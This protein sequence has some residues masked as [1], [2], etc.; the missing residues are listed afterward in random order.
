MSVPAI[1]PGGVRDQGGGIYIVWIVGSWSLVWGLSRRSRNR[2]MHALHGNGPGP[3]GQ[4][5][6]R[7]AT[8]TELASAGFDL[9]LQMADAEFLHLFRR[10]P[11]SA[12]REVLVEAVGASHIVGDD[13]LC[14]DNKRGSPMEA[15][16]FKFGKNSRWGSAA[17]PR[18]MVILPR[19]LTR[20]KERVANELQHN[21][22]V[23]AVV[24]V[25]TVPRSTLDSCKDW[26]SFAA[27]TD[28]TLMNGW[29]DQNEVSSIVAFNLPMVCL[30]YPQQ[31]NAIPPNKWDE[32]PLPV[33]SA[34]VALTVTRRAVEASHTFRK[35]GAFAAMQELQQKS[36]TGLV[37]VVLEVDLV[38][39]P[40]ALRLDLRAFGRRALTDLLKQVDGGSQLPALPLFG[41]TLK[42]D[43]L[44]G[45]VDLPDTIASRLLSVSGKV[46]GVFARPFVNGG[47]D[48]AVPSGFRADSHRVVWAKVARFSDV[49]FGTLQEAKVPFAGLVCPRSRGEMGVRVACGSDVSKLQ[50]CL[51][52][53]VEAKVKVRPDGERR[54]TLRASEVPLAHLD[55]LHLLVARIDENLRLVSSRVIRTSRF[56]MVVDMEVVGPALSTAFW[57]LE[58][59]GMHPVVVKKVERRAPTVAAV[60]VSPTAP[61]PAPKRPLTPGERASWASVVRASNTT[62]VPVAPVPISAAPSSAPA[63]ASLLDDDVEGEVPP[64]TSRKS[65]NPNPSMKAPAP[66]SS[67]ARPA[68]GASS[69]SVSTRP[70]PPA[71]AATSTAGKPSRRSSTERGAITTYLT[72]KVAVTS[73]VEPAPP[74]PST[75]ATLTL[76]LAQL[77]KLTEELAAQRALTERLQQELRS[78]QQQYADL[79]LQMKTVKSKR[80]RSTSPT[81]G[82]SSG[83]EASMSSDPERDRRVAPPRRSPGRHTPPNE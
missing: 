41:V 35:V 46:R 20:V 2:T 82:T 74:T 29:G 45:F 37:R 39:R 4:V 9:R 40:R 71:A 47:V 68:S 81:V 36:R 76:L 53:T 31:E 49:V 6:S 54:A 42:G 34:V 69:S 25:V 55:R 15:A 66:P 1:A 75:D 83:S 18:P 3:R 52:T 62:P 44:R 21:A 19:H 32:S 70:S 22:A 67:N 26:D 17:K 78:S 43:M 58:G 60:R 65:K 12:A 73:P 56:A 64:R 72:P 38:Q 11:T 33:S 13:V 63:Q 7:E 59:L 50:R 14:P 16:M 23:E 5:A 8:K 79:S 57:R 77:N 80:S 28:R 61:V 10:R 30:R 51:E 27:Q 24:V 48:Q